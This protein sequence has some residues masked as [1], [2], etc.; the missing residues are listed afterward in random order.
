LVLIVLII[1]V[2]SCESPSNQLTQTDYTNIS[3]T[4]DSDIDS[5]KVYL[6]IQAPNSVVGMFGIQANDTT[7]ICSQGYFYA[8]QDSTYYLDYSDELF[9][10]NISFDSPPLPCNTAIEIGYLNGINIF[11]GSIN[12]EFEVFDISCV[13][14][15]NSILNVSV[16][17]TTNWSTGTKAN[18]QTFLS[19]QNKLGI[20]SNLNIRGV[21]PYRCTDCIDINPNNVPKNCFNKKIICNTDRICQVARTNKKGGLIN[22][23]YLG[24]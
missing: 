1:G 2:F 22:V 23:Q 10:F 11:E 16:S 13:D 15:V 5:V 3:V 24:Q 14:G 20:D 18:K 21:F 4:N 9:G 12:C 6:T 17:D 8:V 7:G 19:T